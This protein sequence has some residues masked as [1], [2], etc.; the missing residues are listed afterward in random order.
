MTILK[1]LKG[2]TSVVI[3]GAVLLAAYTAYRSFNTPARMD[4]YAVTHNDI[5]DIPPVT[6]SVTWGSF[7]NAGTAMAYIAH[8]NVRL[9][10]QTVRARDKI[11]YTYLRLADGTQ[12]YRAYQ[13]LGRPLDGGAV[14]IPSYTVMGP[15]TCKTWW[16][17]DDSLFGR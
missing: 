6:C 12:S 16:F 3:I 4:L 5:S 9:D 14:E 11:S 7:E 17:P 2:V 13:E 10:I 1:G 8:G 15:A